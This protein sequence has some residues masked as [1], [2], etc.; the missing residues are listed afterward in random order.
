MS[1]VNKYTLFYFSAKVLTHAMVFDRAGAEVTAMGV[2]G[3]VIK[4]LKRLN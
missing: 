3:D 1:P 4:I 2:L